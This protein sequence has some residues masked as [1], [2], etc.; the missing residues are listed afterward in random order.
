[1]TAQHRMVL[2][3]LAMSGALFMLTVA[4]RGARVAVP[5]RAAAAGA[6]APVHPAEGA[7]IPLVPRGAAPAPVSSEDDVH[8]AINAA[9][10]ELERSLRDC[11]ARYSLDLDEVGGRLEFELDLGPSGPIEPAVVGVSGLEGTGLDCVS[12]AFWAAGWPRVE[13]AIHLRVPMAIAVA[14]RTSP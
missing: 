5:I 3:L 10:Q 1:M 12:A 9:E 6:P 7:R 14:H 8:M 13:P 11:G 2:G 4:T